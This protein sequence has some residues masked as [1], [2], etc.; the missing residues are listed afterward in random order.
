MFK[1][2]LLAGATPKYGHKLKNQISPKR[3]WI[4][5]EMAHIVCESYSYLIL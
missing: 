3:P 4:R 5:L 1:N 2:I